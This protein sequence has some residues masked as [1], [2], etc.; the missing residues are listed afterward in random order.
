MGGN[1]PGDQVRAGVLSRAVAV[2]AARIREALPA[3]AALAASG[4]YLVVLQ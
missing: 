3:L 2:R 4:A 1:G